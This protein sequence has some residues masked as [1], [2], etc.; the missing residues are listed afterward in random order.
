MV[1]KSTEYWLV[2]QG[3]GLVRP[4]ITSSDSEDGTP[5]D[6][7]SIGNGLHSRA[8]ESTG[9]FAQHSTSAPALKIS[10]RGVRLNAAASGAPSITAPNVFRVPAVLTADISGIADGNGVTNIVNTATYRW[11]RF[12]ADR[13]TLEADTIGTGSTYTLTD[14]D[15]GKTLKVSVEFT[16]DDGY[17]EG[18]LTSDATDAI[19]AA[20]T[21]AAPSLTGGAAFIGGPRKLTI[22]YSGTALAY[23]FLSSTGDLDDPTFTTAGGSANRILSIGHPDPMATVVADLTVITETA[24]SADDKRT[25]VLHICGDKALRFSSAAGPNSFFFSN[26]G[27]DWSGHAERIIYLSQDTAVPTLVEARVNGT[28]LVM[29]FNEELGAAASLANAAFTV[30]KGSGGTEQTLSGSPSISGRAVT[31]TLATAVSATDT[32]V[33]VAYTKPTTGTANKVVDTFGN[34]AATF[35]DQDVI[36]E[37]ADS[38]PPELA[39]TDAAVLAADG[40]TLTLTY[41]EALKESSVP[42]ASAFTVKATPA[43]GSEAGGGPGVQRRRGGERQHGGAYPGNPHSAQRRLGEGEIRQAGDGRG[44]RGRER[45]RRRGLPGPG[46]DQQQRGAAGEHRAGVRGCNAAAGAPGVPGNPHQHLGERPDREHRGRP[47]RHVPLDDDS[48]GHDPRQPGIG[49]ENPL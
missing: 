10:V 46:G 13:T 47:D 42:A 40:V 9:A 37:L 41:N 12:A 16:D 38:I 43:G 39:A 17:A 24:L 14:R 31:L 26:A 3:S 44:D 34:E 28:S 32:G 27:V 22:G 33:K 30:K 35:P 48:N 25:L 29:T 5:V 1:A 7:A 11:Q 6:G 45:E 36:N 2:V 23:G 18:P 15:A 49:H 21:C 4:Q 20:A 8:D 19:T